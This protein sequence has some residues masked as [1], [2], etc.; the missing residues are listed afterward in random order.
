M[1]VCGAF[2]RSLDDRFR[3]K[4][5]LAYCKRGSREVGGVTVECLHLV[6]FYVDSEPRNKLQLYSY[7]DRI[8]L[9]LTF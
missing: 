7:V 8:P 1:R 5:F 6:A 4:L 3:I 2:V 9:M